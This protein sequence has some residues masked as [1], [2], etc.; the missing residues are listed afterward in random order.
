MKNETRSKEVPVRSLFLLTINPPGKPAVSGV[1]DIF[2]VVR[3]LRAA[4]Q[5]GLVFDFTIVEAP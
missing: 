5:S 3:R 2:D 4:E 1:Y